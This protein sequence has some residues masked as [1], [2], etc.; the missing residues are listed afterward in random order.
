MTDN[1]AA[2]IEPVRTFRPKYATETIKKA[3]RR[4]KDAFGLTHCQA[5]DNIAF[6]LDY[7]SWS[8]LLQSQGYVGKENATHYMPML[9]LGKKATSLFVEIAYMR[10]RNHIS[11]LNLSDGASRS[12]IIEG[13]VAANLP[14]P[15]GPHQ[16][17]MDSVR[18]L[19][20]A[21]VS[22]LMVVLWL[23]DPKVELNLD[24]WPRL[25][26]IAIKTDDI[27]SGFSKLSD[28]ELT[29]RLNRGIKRMER[30]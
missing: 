9:Y 22:E 5:L 17:F 29:T 19:S 21:Q 27:A 1:H 8:D 7:G 6:S 13:L 11:G 20:K 26:G 12:S 16:V 10:Y 14:Q 30:Q 23:G 25:Y 18:K 24:D 28:L 15:T 3:A 2:P 4:Q